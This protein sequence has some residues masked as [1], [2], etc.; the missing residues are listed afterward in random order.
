MRDATFRTALFLLAFVAQS[1]AEVN[2]GETKP[3][4][5]KAVYQ[6]TSESEISYAVDVKIL[7][8]FDSSVS[9]RTSG[10]SGTLAVDQES[11]T[12]MTA[13]QTPVSGEIFVD[14]TTFRSGIGKRDS[15]V[16]RLLES[17][18]YPQ[19]RFSILDIEPR[20][21]SR[22]DALSGTFIVKGRLDIRGKTKEIS[23]PVVISPKSN[24]LAIDGKFSLKLTD[25]G[26]DPPTVAIFV[27]KAKDEILLNVHLIAESKK[28]G[29]FASN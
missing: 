23:F 16:R 11:P 8:A 28:P 3:R 6:I 27:G 20:D 18:K 29:L 22:P 5:E 26:I 13:K 4:V 1:H 12:E 2:M 25:F 14:V 24:K 21:V 7:L 10:I 9:G 17:D 19:I 15:S